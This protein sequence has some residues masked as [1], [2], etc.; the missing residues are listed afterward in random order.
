MTGNTR[1]GKDGGHLVIGLHQHCFPPPPL[2]RSY[3]ILS[4]NWFVLLLWLTKVNSFVRLTAEV[5]L[6][7]MSLNSVNYM[8]WFWQKNP[9]PHP[10]LWMSSDHGALLISSVF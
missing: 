3:I 6:G 8:Q 1:V 9:M 4:P 2:T 10:R 5:L 7:I